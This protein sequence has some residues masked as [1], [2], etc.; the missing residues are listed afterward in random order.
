MSTGSVVKYKIV[1]FITNISQIQHLL[2]KIEFSF[3]VC[4]QVCVCFTFNAFVHILI[5]DNYIQRLLVLD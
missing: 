1:L 3:V 5:L 2:F 4:F